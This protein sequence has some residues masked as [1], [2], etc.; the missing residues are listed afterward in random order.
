MRYFLLRA[1]S[2]IVFMALGASIAPR[3]SA[4]VGDAWQLIAE[5]NALRASYGL[6]AYEVNSALM[7]AAQS[8][9]EYQASIGTWTHS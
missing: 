2:L 3:S 5:V 7:A 6:P 4:Q 9:S 8:H 1:F